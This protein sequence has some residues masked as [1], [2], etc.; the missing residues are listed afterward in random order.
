MNRGARVCNI[1]TRLYISLISD[2]EFLTA[3]EDGLNFIRRLSAT[4][5]IQII[6]INAYQNF[7]FNLSYILV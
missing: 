1:F 7:A 3:R 6:L 4:S 2:N 5:F